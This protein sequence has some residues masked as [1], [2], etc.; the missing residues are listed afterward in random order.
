[1]TKRLLFAKNRSSCRIHTAFKHNNAASNKFH[2]VNAM[3]RHRQ[4]RGAMNI[5]DD[6]CGNGCRFLILRSVVAWDYQRP[7]MRTI[8]FC[9]LCCCETSMTSATAAATNQYYSY[10]G[11]IISPPP[12]S[13]LSISYTLLILKSR[14]FAQKQ[15]LCSFPLTEIHKLILF[16]TNWYCFSNLIDIFLL[17]ELLRN[18]NRSLFPVPLIGS[19]IFSQVQTITISASCAEAATSEHLWLF[20]WHC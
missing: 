2:N 9:F 18:E 20:L 7:S 10:P 19:R 13:V 8:S 11:T 17:Y 16:F 6:K 1:M 4:F 14:C 12:Q 3:L 15:L 5:T